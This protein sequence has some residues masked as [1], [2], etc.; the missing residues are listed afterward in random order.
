MAVYAEAH[1][2]GDVLPG[3]WRRVAADECAGDAALSVLAGMA[4]VGEIYACAD[5]PAYQA[6]SAELAG[7]HN[8]WPETPRISYDSTLYVQALWRRL[9]AM[10]YLRCAPALQAWADGV[11]H[12]HCGERPVV[13]LHLKNVPNGTGASNA[14]QAVWHTFLNTATENYGTG[15]LLI[16]DDRVEARISGLPGVL[17][18]RAI[19]A[20]SFSRH[21]ALLMQADAFMGMMSGPCNGAIFSD[22]PYAIFKHPDHHRDEMLSEIGDQDHYCF[23]QPGQRV[24]RVEE[25]PEILLAELARMPFLLGGEA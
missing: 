9:G 1:G 21:L 17:S 19:G 13:A 22:K 2:I 14:R 7:T 8:A 23:A 16:G 11:L 25:T 10:V 3:R 12:R 20:D 15:F 18:A 5:W 4:S 6:L 24:L